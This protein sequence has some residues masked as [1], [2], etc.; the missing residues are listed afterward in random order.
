M[1]FGSKLTLWYGFVF[2]VAAVALLLA[3]YHLLD[4]SMDKEWR[5]TRSKIVAEWSGEPDGTVSEVEV[6]AQRAVI[7]GTVPLDLNVESHLQRAFYKVALPILIVGLALGWFVTHAGLRPLRSLGQTVRYILT[8]GK[9]SARVPVHSERGE[10]NALVGLFNQMLDKNEKLMSAMHES[11]DNVAHD[12]R[13]PMTRLRGSAENALRK[14]EDA[15]SCH[16][17]LKDC[18]EESNHVLTMLNTLMDVAEAETGAMPLNRED[19]RLRELAGKVIE[20]YELVAEDSGV[21]VA[22]DIPEHLSVHADPTRLRQVLNNLVDNAIKYSQE[23]QRVIISAREVNRHTELSVTDQGA[24]IP[25][26]EQDKIWDRLYRGDLSRSQRGL[27]LGLSLVKAIVEAHGGSVGVRSE[28][29][30]GSC[31]TLR[32][33]R[34]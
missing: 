7:E 29:N 27:G 4:D 31:F 8:T 25:S 32:F 9:T 15:T 28:V 24:G 12:L 6:T 19:V 22:A 5:V 2:I 34:Q 1:T 14:S 16:E 13:T 33:P 21:T 23:G 18:M 11:L 17:A 26:G 10:L 3:V 30:K 20:V